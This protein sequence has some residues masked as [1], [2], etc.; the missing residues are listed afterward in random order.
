MVAATPEQ[1]L[2][3]VCRACPRRAVA[4]GTLGLQAGLEMADLIM[5]EIRNRELSMDLRRVE[6][7]SGCHH[8]CS[9]RVS[10]KGKASFQFRGVRHEHIEDL[11]EF[12]ALYAGDNAGVLKDAALAHARPGRSFD[13]VPALSSPSLYA[14]YQLDADC[15]AGLVRD[16]QSLSGPERN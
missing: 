13:P 16:L 15:V 12:L 5:A 9:V 7:L 3:F 6:C 2:V 8:P 14:P 4:G 11:G 10:A 1:G